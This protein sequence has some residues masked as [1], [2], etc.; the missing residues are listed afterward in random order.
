ML[1]SF[2]VSGSFRRSGKTGR[3]IFKYIPQSRLS[4]SYIK[5]WWEKVRDC[6]APRSCDDLYRFDS[7]KSLKKKQVFY[8]SE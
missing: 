6:D 3:D 7:M 5:G 8:K 4:D 2:S 1:N